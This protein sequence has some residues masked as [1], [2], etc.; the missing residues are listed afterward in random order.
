MKHIQ[1]RKNKLSHVK[2]YKLKKFELKEKT[3]KSAREEK[4]KNLHIEKIQEKIYPYFQRKCRIKYNFLYNYNAI[5]FLP[6]FGFFFSFF[7][8]RF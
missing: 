7:K 8:K 2:S 6:K 4:K 5:F 1:K 3:K